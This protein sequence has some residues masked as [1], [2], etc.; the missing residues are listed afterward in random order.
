MTEWFGY[1]SV[2]AKI[3]FIPHQMHAKGLSWD[4]GHMEYTC[5][6]GVRV[7]CRFERKGS[8][9]RNGL[10]IEWK[11]APNLVVGETQMSRDAATVVR[12]SRAKT[13]AFPRSATMAGNLAFD[14]KGGL[15][16]VTLNEGL[17]W[18]ASYCFRETGIRRLVLPSSVTDIGPRAFTLCYNLQFADL[19]AAGLKELGQDTFF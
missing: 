7:R 1:S 11:R 9:P 16:S 12:G 10:Q 8:V 13:Y 17:D 2:F 18:I 3:S 5:A 19:R 4:G 6:D 15:R 14:D